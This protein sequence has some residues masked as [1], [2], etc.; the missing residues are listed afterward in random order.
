MKSLT[1]V[2][3]AR[4]SCCRKMP[5]QTKAS[6]TSAIEPAHGRFRAFRNDGLHGRKALVKGLFHGPPVILSFTAQDEGNHVLTGR[7]GAD[8]DPQADEVFSPAVFDDVFEAIVAAGRSL[9]ANPDF[10]RR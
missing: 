3:V 6:N 1:K 10:C 4:G 5:L 8:P 7:Q 2:T 9:R